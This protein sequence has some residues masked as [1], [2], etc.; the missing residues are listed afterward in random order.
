L[1]VDDESVGDSVSP[2]LVDS[3]GRICLVSREF[4]DKRFDRSGAFGGLKLDL[5]ELDIRRTALVWL[6]VEFKGSFAGATGLE[7]L[8]LRRDALTWPEELEIELESLDE[9]RSDLESFRELL[10]TGG[11]F[12]GSAVVDLG[13][14][15][16]E[17]WYF[18]GGLD[19]DSVGDEESRS[20]REEVEVLGRREAFTLLGNMG[21]AE[22]VASVEFMLILASCGRRS[23]VWTTCLWFAGQAG[24]QRAS[25]EALDGCLLCL[26][27]S[28]SGM[29]FL[30]DHQSVP[31]CFHIPMTFCNSSRWT[32][33][34]ISGQ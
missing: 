29:H 3:E 33:N 16:P 8:E 9:R 6:E 34:K 27:A 31:T 5:E 28:W 32:G 7:V 13:A 4:W 14:L 1:G 25:A 18:L 23:I 21:D 30:C 11:R 24:R 12:V 22:L 10:V 20:R 17:S 26:G 19:L 2:L 15:W